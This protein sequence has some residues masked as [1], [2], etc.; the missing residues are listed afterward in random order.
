MS[1]PA[2]IFD[3]VRT[4]RS[5]GKADGS[6]HGVKPIDLGAGLLRELQSRHQLD[7]SYVDDVVM[8]CVT[9]VGEQ[10]SDVAKMIE[11]PVFHVNGDD[12]EAVTMITEL[13]LDFR[14]KFH[15][16]V[17]IDMV[18]FRRL[19]HNEQDDPMVTQPRMYQIINQHPGTRQ[20]YADKLEAEGVILRGS[21]IK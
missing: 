8:G 16:D 12:P 1:N 11:A 6:L 17:V 2:Y 13:A 3:A 10:G 15:K 19:G 9:P 21:P 4:P 18:C 20:R 5:K 7:T 14:M